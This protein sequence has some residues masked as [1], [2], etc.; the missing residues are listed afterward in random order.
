MTWSTPRTWTSSEVVTAANVN[1]YISDNLTALGTPPFA[2]VYATAPGNTSGTS[3][4]FTAI[5]FNS[6]ISDTYSMHDPSTNPTR[7]T[8][9]WDGVYMV[10]GGFT[11]A[12]QASA[13]LLRMYFGTNGSAPTGTRDYAYVPSTATLSGFTGITGSRFLRLS[14]T[15]YVELYISCSA[16]T[17]AIQNA[18]GIRP[19]L[20]VRW[21]GP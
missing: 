3:S 13:A 6:E 21:V 16:T 15:N 9:P 2:D 7:I 10:N 1:T 17:V 4:T 8:V 11:I 5:S 20:Q 18:D 12:N 14:S 19:F